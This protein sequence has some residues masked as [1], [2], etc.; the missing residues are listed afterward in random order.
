M[1]DNAARYGILLIVVLALSPVLAVAQTVDVILKGVVKDQS[2]AVL[3]G[4]TV[5]AT[6]TTTN[7][8]RP[9]T[10]DRAGYYSLPP[11]P[12]GTYDVSAELAGFSTQVRRNQIFHVGTSITLDFTMKPA[13]ASEE[14]VVTAAAPVL[15][16]TQ[17]TLSRLVQKDEIDTLPVVTRNFNDLAALAPGVSRTGVFGGVDISGSRDFQNGYNV[18]GLT[19]ETNIVGSQSINYSQDWI[20]EFQVLT[21]QFPAE[22]GQASGG[23]LNAITRSGSNQLSGRLYAFVRKDSWDAAPAFVTRKP[24]LDEKRVGF[25]LGG[26]IIRDRLFF[27]TGFEGLNNKSSNI[28]T[29]AFPSS[30]GIFPSK[31]DEKLFLGKLDY[32]PAS[33]STFRVRYNF[34]HRNTAGASIGGT[35]TEEHGRFSHDRNWDVLGIWNQSISA[36][37]FNEARAALNHWEQNGGCNYATRNPIGT[38]FERSYPG[39]SFGCPVNFG[40]LF[41]EQTQVIDNLSWVVGRHDAKAGFQVIRTRFGDFRNFRDG[42]Y[43]F[44]RDIAFSPDN[45]ASYPVA[46]TIFQGPTAFKVPSWSYG[47]FIQDSWRTNENFTLNLGLRY[48]LDGTFTALNPFVRTDKGLHTIKKDTN[49]V[50]PRVGFAWTPFGDN[51]R[52]LIRGGGGLYYDQNHNNLAGI[53]FLNN[54]LVDKIVTINANSPLLNPFW[55]DVDKARKFLADALARNTIPDVSS[56]SGLVGGTNDLDPNLRIP[57]TAQATLGIARDFNGGLSA[58]ADLVYSHG[59]DQ[60]IFKE[61]NVDRDAAVNEHKVVRINKNYTSIGAAANGGKFDYKALQLQATYRPSARHMAK[62]AYTLAKNTSN[63]VLQTLNGGFVTNPFDLEIDKGPTDND[64]R[65]TISL[66]GSTTLPL[67]VEFSAIAY[68]RSALPYSATTTRLLGPGPF[69]QRPEPRNSRRGDEFFSLDARLGKGFDIARRVTATFFVEGFNLTNST[70]YSS[71]VGN[72]DSAL[73]AK[74]TAASPKRRSQV[75]LRVDF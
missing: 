62:L 5:M 13:P 58:S 64:V 12:A 44:G 70:N 36:G 30:N 4:V 40:L 56:I 54:I 59:I 46:F 50:S 45:P 41:E 34:Q 57:A 69:S 32:Q 23:I 21:N 6:N 37:L 73:F 20:Q 27:F 9:T 1:K 15:E 61:V 2:G 35:S 55:P 53:L 63:T 7:F 10:T 75:G 48:D 68:Y 43:T 60:L 49:N 11:I 24:P 39:G 47:A 52:T 19:S 16:T 8:T 65:H 22:F 3:P 51:K 26:P 42:R 38:W 18:D 66:N 28:V 17:N 74:P 71:F 25:T 29:S 14:I 31:T 33:S 72:I 67:N